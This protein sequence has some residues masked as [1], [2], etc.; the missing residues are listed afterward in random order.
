ME[1]V[2]GSSFFSSLCCCFCSLRSCCVYPISL[3]EFTL[4]SRISASA[5]SA[6]FGLGD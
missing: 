6:V 3:P 2:I 5:G 1:R 4:V